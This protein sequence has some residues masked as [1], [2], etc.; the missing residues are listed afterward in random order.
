MGQSTRLEAFDR[1]RKHRLSILFESF[2]LR[3][4]LAAQRTFQILTAVLGKFAIELLE[5]IELRNGHHEIAPGES[6]EAF[7]VT[8]LVR[9]THKAEV[10]VVEIIRLQSQE[11][12]CRS[13]AASA[14][15]LRHG[16]LR[17]VVADPLRHAAEELERTDV[18]RL[19]RL[20]A[21]AGK[22]LTEKC[23]AVR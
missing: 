1:N 14:D 23:V 4:T 7:R 9:A 13:L 8:L 5:V 20:G 11:L 10:V 22:R 19:E 3:A 17:V 2:G 16:D 12:P 6:D 15:N 21:F 18:A